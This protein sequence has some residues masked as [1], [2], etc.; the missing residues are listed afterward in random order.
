[1]SEVYKSVGRMELFWF[2]G[3]VKPCHESRVQELLTRMG[4]ECYLP[5]QKVKRK[6][7]DRTKV[8]DVKILP[9]RIFVRTTK[10]NRIQLLR[11]FPYGSIYAFMTNG[12]AHNPVIIPDN[13]MATFRAMVDGSNDQ[14]VTFVN[15]PLKAGDRVKVVQ[16][17]L[18][19]MECEI[20][21]INGKKCFAV[22]MGPLGIATLEVTT[23]ALE[24][25]ELSED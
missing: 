9:G 2:V 21:Q 15:L 24:R 23:D 16:G 7:S 4:V 14:L 12:G 5:V 22:P 25:V 18:A 1:M 17:P 6:W 13:Q 11:D 8:V 10:E 19:G 20:T 3:F